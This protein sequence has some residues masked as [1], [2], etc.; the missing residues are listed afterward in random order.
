MPSAASLF[1][2]IIACY[3]YSS[4]K[5]PEKYGHLGIVKPPLPRYARSGVLFNNS[6]GAA[7]IF[8]SAGLMNTR[9]GKDIAEQTGFRQPL[10]KRGGSSRF[11]LFHDTEKIAAT[12]LLKI[13]PGI[14]AL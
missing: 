8:F 7:P 3:K 6:F 9:Y 14:A 13:R 11:D 1:F 12:E 5:A 4:D 10:L 2:C